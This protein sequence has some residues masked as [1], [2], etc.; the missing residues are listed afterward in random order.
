MR[1]LQHMNQWE[2]IRRCVFL[3]LEKPISAIYLYLHPRTSKRPTIPLHSPPLSVSVSVSLPS[4]TS[5]SVSLSSSLSSTC[6]IFFFPVRFTGAFPDVPPVLR[7]DI[8]PARE[9]VAGVL[10]G[11]FKGGEGY[12]YLHRVQRSRLRRPFRLLWHYLQFR[13]RRLVYCRSPCSCRRRYA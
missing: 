7:A 10:M 5:P 13:A 4:S 3:K 11:Y 1:T 9:S 6:S 2:W 8:W 12:M